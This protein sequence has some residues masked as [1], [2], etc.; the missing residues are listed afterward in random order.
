M[1]FFTIIPD[2]Y[3][4]IYMKG[5][6]RQAPLYLRGKNVHAKWGGGFIRLSQGGATSHPNV[7]WAEF[8]AGA[9]A[10]SEAGGNV[11]Y[12]PPVGEVVSAV[13]AE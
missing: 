11:T 5:V 1:D 6:Y 13:A 12:L 10:L 7:R 4:V 3:A 2:A 8:D 9:G